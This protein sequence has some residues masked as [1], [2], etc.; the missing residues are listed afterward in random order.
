MATSKLNLLLGHISAIWSPPPSA[1]DTLFSPSLFRS[2]FRC[3][4]LHRT[5]VAQGRTLAKLGGCATSPYSEDMAHPP[6]VCQLRPQTEKPRCK[7]SEASR[8]CRPV[9]SAPDRE[10]YLDRYA[11][12]DS[13][14]G[15][16]RDLC[17]PLKCFCHR[18][19]VRAAFGPV[20]THLIDDG[21]RT[22]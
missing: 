18:N 6:W 19:M 3:R 21:C 2:Y 22:C 20:D 8:G 10:I 11:S 13:P 9:R 15:L 4:L 7:E 5:I 1:H 17:I 16:K 12:S 14:R